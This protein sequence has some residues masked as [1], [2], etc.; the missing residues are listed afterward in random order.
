MCVGGWR[1]YVRADEV[2]SYTR[3]FPMREYLNLEVNF[4]ETASKVTT[5]HQ[6][7]NMLH[8]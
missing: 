4:M 2:G 6:Q 8:K 7:L 5:T 1:V 3:L